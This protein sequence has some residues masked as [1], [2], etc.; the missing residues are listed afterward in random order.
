[1]NIKNNIIKHNLKNV[2]FVCGTA[3]GG[4]TTMARLIAEKY[5]YYLYDMDK[6][7][8]QHR[9]IADEFNQ[10]NMCYHL[11][12]FHKQYT[13]NPQEMALWNMSSLREQTEM[14]LI[15]LMALSKNQK[16]VADVLYSPAYTSEILDYNQIAFLVVDKKVIRKTYFNRPEKRG[17]YE[18]VK[19]QELSELYFDNIFKGLELTNELEQAKMKESGFFVY[20]RQKNDTYESVLDILEKHYDLK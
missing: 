17:F 16:V 13:R 2:I 5:N 1:M 19:K 4:K 11:K 3:C 15:D 10:P 6:M 14:V 18:F 20:E 12:D 7:Y 8:A 9:S